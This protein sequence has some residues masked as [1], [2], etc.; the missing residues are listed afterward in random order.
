MF[1]CGAS[2]QGQSKDKRTAAAAVSGQRRSGER[3]ACRGCHETVKNSYAFAR[4]FLGWQRLSLIC[5]TV[6][7]EAP[8]LCA[9]LNPLHIRAHAGV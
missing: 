5:N 6:G 3:A 4:R 7:V 8:T 9:R 1:L 2:S